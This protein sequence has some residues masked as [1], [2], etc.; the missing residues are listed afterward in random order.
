MDEGL[1]W[2]VPVVLATLGALFFAA[3]RAGAAAEAQFWGSGFALSAAAF[4]FPL[5]DALIPTKIIAFVSDTAFATAY[6]C[7]AWALIIRYGGRRLLRARVALLVA[8]VIAPIYGIFVV[9]SLPAEV[10][11]SDLTCMVQLAFA[12]VTIRRW[13]AT[14]ID[15][16]IVAIS[17]T[18][19]AQNLLLT[20]SIPL[21]IAGADPTDFFGTTYSD[22]MFSWALLTYLGF[23]LLAL[24]AV[25]SELVNGHRNDA[26]VD[27]L[28]GL[29]NRR[30]LD[31][32]ASE[33][34]PRQ[35]D[36]VIVCDLDRFKQVNDTWGHEAGDNV[37]QAFAELVREVVGS[38][39]VAARTGGEEFVLYLPGAPAHLAASTA[40]ALQTAMRRF[41]WS[42]TGITGPQTASFGVSTRRH[43]EA[44]EHALRRAD[45]LVYT[46]KRNGRDRIEV[47]GSSD[48]LKLSVATA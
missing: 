35:G 16:G 1:A 43:S 29:L 31:Q 18:I 14:W 6:L 10:L 20:A 38:A 46:A 24:S 26:L 25:M 44:L 36:C 4:A 48:G 42:S 15:R 28:T 47:D 30:G 3:R 23:A 8:G 12:L 7:Y 19:V 32:A 5:T 2:A 34:R 21:T 37:L 45:R 13:P 41:D 11:A 27:P 22:L 40:K 33:P 39:G 9:D 17:W